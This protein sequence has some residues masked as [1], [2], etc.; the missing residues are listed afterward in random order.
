MQRFTLGKVGV[1]YLTV[2]QR[3]VLLIFWEKVMAWMGLIFMPS[4]TL[5]KNLLASLL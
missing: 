1:A 2:S 3:T 5:R 4:E